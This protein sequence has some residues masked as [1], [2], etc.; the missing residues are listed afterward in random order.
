M[1]LSYKILLIDDQYESAALQDFV[2]NASY[3]G[4]EIDCVGF[5]NEGIEILKNDRQGVYQAVILDA[6]GYKSAQDFEAGKDLNNVGLIH[7]LRYLESSKSER[8]IPWFI[9]SGAPRNIGN[10]EFVENIKVYQADY[11][12]GRSDIYYY[13]KSQDEGAL[14]EDIKV[15]VDKLLRTRVLLQYDDVFNA[16]RGIPNLDKHRST[17]IEI[18]ENLSTNQ[19]YTKVRKVIESLF[20][21]LADISILPEGFT[22]EVGW[23][24]G[25]SRFLTCNHKDFNFYEPEFIHPTICEILFR[26]LNIVQDGSHNEGS[27]K[28]RVDEYSKLYKSGYLY[29]SIVY[30]LLE[31]ICYFGELIKNNPD[32]EKNKTRWMKIENW[33]EGTI[34]ELKPNGWAD[35]VSD[36]KKYNFGIPESFVSSCFKIGIKCRVQLKKENQKHV[37][38]VEIM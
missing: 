37:S 35:F 2:L 24:N 11:K 32:K 16:I 26:L 36:C 10:E 8:V 27:L 28:Y 20:Q 34:T 15:E 38:K 29:Q 1:I 4:I 14:F 19:D 33:I 5:H 6:T 31:I 25:T 21:A 22:K 12:F 18:L 7:S 17:L 23:I 9:Y 30:A 3:E 13:V